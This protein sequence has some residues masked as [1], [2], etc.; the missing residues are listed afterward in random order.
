M[1]KTIDDY[2]IAVYSFSAVY[3]YYNYK[4]S[5][6]L[7][8][9]ADSWCSNYKSN[10]ID[11]EVNYVICYD[12]SKI[13]I[14]KE[15]CMRGAFTIEI[16]YDRRSAYVDIIR[17]INDMVGRDGMVTLAVN[18]NP[19]NLKSCLIVEDTENPEC[20]AEFIR[21]NDLRINHEKGLKEIMIEYGNRMW[22]LIP[23][24]P[25]SDNEEIEMFMNAA[26]HFKEK[27]ELTEQGY[28]F[29]EYRRPKVFISYSH[30]DEDVVMKVYGRMQLAGIN[31]WLDA[32]AIDTG[33]IIP[34][35]MLEGIKE[36]DFAVL[37]LSESYK[38]SMFAKA[39]LHHLLSSIFRE[40]KKWYPI[41]LDNVNVD[42]IQPGLSNYKY[43][44]LAHKPDIDTL[45]CDMKNVF[46]LD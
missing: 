21:R 19:Y 7:Y 8:F 12:T 5:K 9:F 33:D 10:N 25:G 17:Q 35:K 38:E 43:Y 42:D 14:Y 31:I 2:V 4:D 28:D 39:E 30:K 24:F 20:I 11:I 16:P 29:S 45:V 32:Y 41:R 3:K 46:K 6:L 44:D 37:F 27:E 1:R 36:S 18:N 15:N 22:D 26:Y 40:E 23:I 13:I 34:R